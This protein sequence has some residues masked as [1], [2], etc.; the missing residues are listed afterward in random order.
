V[1]EPTPDRDGYG[2]AEAADTVI[3]DA[4]DTVVADAADTVVIHRRRSRRSLVLALFGAV[5]LI[6]VA[7]LIGRLVTHPSAPSSGQQPLE[8]PSTQ[9][10]VPPTGGGGTGPTPTLPALPTRPADALATWATKVGGALGIP[11]T[12]VQAYGYAQLAIGQFDPACHLN[13]TTLAAIGAVQSQHGQLGGAILLPTGRSQPPIQSPPLDGLQG[14]PLVRDTDAGAFD[15]DPAFD[16]QMG[17][18]KLLPS[19]WQ[20]FATDADGDGISDPYDIDD[21][22]LTLGR[23]LCAGGADLSTSTGWR[24]AIARYQPGTTFASAIFAVADD[25]GRRSR[26]V[27]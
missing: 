20:Q 8:N 14:R 6:V 5:V 3:P 2:S 22:S 7:A 27:G 4:A 23:L 25:Y 17:P 18:M 21:A 16:R 11:E 24:A 1:A 26:S 19:Q 12:A 10:V 15:G 13:W 9:P